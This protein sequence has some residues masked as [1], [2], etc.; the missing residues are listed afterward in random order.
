MTSLGHDA[1]QTKKGWEMV[2]TAVSSSVRWPPSAVGGL[3]SPTHFSLDDIWGLSSPEA[4]SG[5]KKT[6]PTHKS[7]LSPRGG[8]T[9]VGH[10]HMALCAH[11]LPEKPTSHC[12]CPTENGCWAKDRE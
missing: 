8:T 12:G 1:P 11:T 5:A 2:L 3:G 7:T 10:E 4:D 6:F 9:H